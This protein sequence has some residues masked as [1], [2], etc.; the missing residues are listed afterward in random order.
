MSDFAGRAQSQSNRGSLVRVGV[1]LAVVAGIGASAPTASLA[2]GGRS[3]SSARSALRI[4]QGT[5]RAVFKHLLH[6]HLRPAPLWPQ[7]LPRKSRHG[8]W[9]VEGTGGARIDPCC[10]NTLANGPSAYSVSFVYRFRRGHHRTSNFMAGGFGRTS[11]RSFYRTVPI[12]APQLRSTPSCAA[13]RSP[14]DLFLLPQ[15]PLVGF[16]P[17]G[18]RIRLRDSLR[19]LSSHAGAQSH[20]RLSTADHSACPPSLEGPHSDPEGSTTGAPAC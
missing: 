10:A 14:G 9:L 6:A 3:S 2:T 5:E 1:V 17:R 16:R 19:P 4:F 18:Q 8:R 20:D 13:R 11:A 15:L 12:L 7:S